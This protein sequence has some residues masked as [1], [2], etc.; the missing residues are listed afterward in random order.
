MGACYL[1]HIS[2]DL[3]LLFD[4][5][6]DLRLRLLL[7]CGPRVQQLHVALVKRLQ[8]AVFRSQQLSRGGQAVVQPLLV[9]LLQRP[10][11]LVAERR[12]PAHAAPRVNTKAKIQRPC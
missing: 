8:L 10:H 12:Q 1:L 6:V 5:S 2:H 3:P 4:Q 9:L 7:S 11:E